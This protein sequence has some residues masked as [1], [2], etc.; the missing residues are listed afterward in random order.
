MA[1]PLV[2][3]L[4]KNVLG[5]LASE[6]LVSKLVKNVLGKLASHAC[7]EIFMGWGFRK[8]IGKLSNTLE[9]MK[10]VLLDAEE[11]PVESHE[12]R[13]WL[14]NLKD[15]CYD[16]EDILDEFEIEAVRREVVHRMSVGKKVCNFFSFSN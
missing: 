11:R 13:V 3:K 7:E 8:D 14:D 12:R 4:V 2:S 10:A 5:K 9:S 16:A 1:E 15:I 6:P